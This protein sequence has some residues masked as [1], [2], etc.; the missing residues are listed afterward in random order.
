MDRIDY[1]F[2]LE[3]RATGIVMD[4]IDFC[5]GDF[6]DSTEGVYDSPFNEEEI[7]LTELLNILEKNT[8]IDFN[9]YW[10]NNMEESLIINLM[11]FFTD[12]AHLI[13]GINCYFN[14]RTIKKIKNFI[15]RINERYEPKAFL[16]WG[17]DLP[18]LDSFSFLKQS[19]NSIMTLQNLKTFL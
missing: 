9:L 18:P 1:Y 12:D 6:I 16:F 4:F 17:E 5:G 10:N 11:A 8:N 2:L 3:N 15:E 7:T 14:R 13:L 19:E